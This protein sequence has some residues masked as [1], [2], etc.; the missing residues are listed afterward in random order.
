[1]ENS[2]QVEASTQPVVFNDST[3]SIYVAFSLMGSGILN[4]TVDTKAMTKTYHVRTDW[5]KFQLDLT[6]EISLD[7]TK[8][9]GAQRINYTLNKETHV[10]Y[11]Y[12]LTGS[13][14]LFHFVLPVEA[15]NVQAMEDTIIYDVPLPFGDSLLNSPFLILGA[16]LVVVIALS[17]YRKVRK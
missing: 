15:S 6:P 12:N 9:V 3:S 1:L 16:L 2:E 14:T 13:D 10:A 8:P 4:F 11:L 5:R 7:F 17:V